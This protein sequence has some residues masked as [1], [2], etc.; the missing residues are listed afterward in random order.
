M[1]KHSEKPSVRTQF[2][3]FTLFG[4][5]FLARGGNVWTSHLLRL[6]G[7]LGVSE[8]ATRSTLSRMAQKGWLTASKHGRL[9]RYAITPRGWMLLTQGEQRIFEPTVT[10]WDGIWQIVVYSLPEKERRLRHNLRQA[11]TWLGFGALAPGTWIS[12]HNRK[13]ELKNYCNDLGIQQY[14]EIF[15]GVH[16]GLSHEKDLVQRC[17][18]FEKIAANYQKFIQRYESDYE[19][20]QN[21]NIPSPKDCFVERFWIT[22]HFQNFPRED[23]NLPTA[24]LPTNW[25]GFKARDLFENYRQLLE[26]RA[27]Q[28]A[29]EIIGEERIDLSKQMVNIFNQGAKQANQEGYRTNRAESRITN[30]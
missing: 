1:V 27:N 16:L 17:W 3:V 25:V 4:D 20:C 6:L 10:D 18:D 14:V 9:S 5:Y 21:G 30:R 12:P 2:L 26:A 15:S 23:P 28:Y 19:K 7:L 8:R 13:V 24:L 11:L 22:H 29:D